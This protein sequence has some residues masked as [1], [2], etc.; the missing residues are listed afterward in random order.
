MLFILIINLLNF[1]RLGAEIIASSQI[2]K[3]YSNSTNN[4]SCNPALLISLTVDNSQTI[5]TEYINITNIDNTSSLATPLII[6]VTKTPVYAYYPLIYKNDYNSKPYETSIPCSILGCDDD[7]NSNQPTCGFQ[8][9]SSGNKIFGSQGF[10]CSCSLFDLIGITDTYARG[11][12][13]KAAQI[14]T[15]SMA[16]CLR[17]SDL[18]YR[19]DILQKQSAFEIQQY[20]LYYELNGTNQTIKLGS[21]VN[22]ANGTNI[23]TRIVGDFTPLSPPPT[24]QSYQL[25]KPTSP[26]SNARVQAGSSAWMLIPSNMIGSD[27]NKIGVTYASFQQQ[28]SKCSA[29]VGSCLKNQIEDLYES[30]QK[31]IQNSTTPQYMLSRFGNFS[32]I[33]NGTILRYN[34]QGQMNTLITLELNGSYKL[35]FITQLSKGTIDFAE[36][37]NFESQ[38]GNGTIYAQITNIGTLAAQFNTFLNC[39]KNVYPMN[40]QSIYLAPL[41][42]QKITQ[43]VNVLSDLNSSNLCNFTLMDNQGVQLD[44]KQLQ[45]NTTQIVYQSPQN[46]SNQTTKEGEINATEAT[47]INPCQACSTLFD[48]L[49]YIENDCS[50]QTAT[51][52]SLLIATIFIFCCCGLIAKYRKCCCFKWC[53]SNKQKSAKIDQQIYI[54]KQ[55]DQSQNNQESFLQSIQEISKI[56]YLNLRQGDDC[57][58]DQLGYDLS[59]KTVCKFQGQELIKINIR[60]QSELVVI[61]KE[62][63]GSESGVTKYL[64]KKKEKYMEDQYILTNQPKY[65]L[66]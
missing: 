59:V 50:A 65:S 48:V 57:I 58:A 31:L 2:T 29:Q 24:L 32:F 45:F 33:N 64:Q 44:S 6:S 53:F 23:I 25:L 38:S 42:S 7:A 8:K 63:Y 35:S 39:S 12:I 13:C 1:T 28:S 11:N 46:H 43:Q 47:I 54:Q 17:F 14:S 49:C 27:C 56:K 15:A 36:I 18:W 26:L 61:F 3:C 34:V 5:A 62:L 51:F 52:F 19:Y 22:Q 66:I 20:Y 41:S 9:D 40:S 16:F 10:C 60:R 4:T 30:D 21:Q 37:N 55:A